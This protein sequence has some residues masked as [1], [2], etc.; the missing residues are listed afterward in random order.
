MDDFATFAAVGRAQDLIAQIVGVGVAL[1]MTT[2]PPAVR[3]TGVLPES[4][5]AL[6][7]LKKGLIILKVN[8]ASTVGKSLNECLELIRGPLGDKVRSILNREDQTIRLG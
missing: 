3:I 4:S 6:A 1:E 2:E 5:F 7:G 8:E